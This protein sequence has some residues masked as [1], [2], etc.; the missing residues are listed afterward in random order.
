M[1]KSAACGYADYSQIDLLGMLQVDSLEREKGQLSAEVRVLHARTEDL[2]RVCPSTLN[3]QPSTRN[4]KHETQKPKPEIPNSK[5]ET[6][7]PKVRVLHARTEDLARVCPNLLPYSP[8][9]L[10]T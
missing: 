5:P 1:K 7:S 9:F 2:E 4:L 3:P 6:R 8:Q 10:A